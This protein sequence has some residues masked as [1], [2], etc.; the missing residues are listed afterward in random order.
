MQHG[1]TTSGDFNDE[2]LTFTVTVDT[3]T[4]LQFYAL[5]GDDIPR[6][7]V[8]RD[9]NGLI[10][11]SDGDPND[12]SVD[13]GINVESASPGVYY[14]EIDGDDDEFSDF[15]VS[16][17]CFTSFPTTEPTSNPTTLPSST[18]STTTTMTPTFE[19]TPNPSTTPSI[20]PT[21]MAPTSSPTDS[22]SMEPTVIPSESPTE[23]VSSFQ[24]R[25]IECGESTDG[26]FCC[27]TVTNVAVF[28][29]AV[30]AGTVTF[31][32]SLS[33][34]S[35]NLSGIGVVLYRGHGHS[36]GID[37]G[38]TIALSTVSDRLTVADLPS[39]NYTAAMGMFLE[40]ECLSEVMIVD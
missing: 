28:I 19:P 15:N 7:V 25:T 4:N 24:N 5:I 13:G 21:S 1:M 9:S 34:D 29:D 17:L 27:G 32:W 30:N 2:L 12:G 18:T 20:E 37:F 36:G 3:V 39:G 16:L 14:L 10:M 6:S 22:P 26:S 8:L 31:D 40:S 23:S 38:D 11:V 33:T 35:G